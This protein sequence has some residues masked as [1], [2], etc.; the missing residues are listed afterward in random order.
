MKK[1]TEDRKKLIAERLSFARKSAGLSQ[2]QVAKMLQMHRPTIS[3]IEAGRRK[4]SVE[5]LVHFAELYKVNM[6]WLAGKKL[7]EENEVKS[8]IEIAARQ[9]KNLKKEDLDKV[10]DLLTALRE[11]KRDS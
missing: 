11:S 2:G 10:I 3:E 5:E 7:D 9:L 8:E 4:V 6:Q 1:N